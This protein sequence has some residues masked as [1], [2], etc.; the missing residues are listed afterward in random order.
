[1][2]KNIVVACVTGVAR[3]MVACH[4]KDFLPKANKPSQ[5]IYTERVCLYFI[6]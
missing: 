6:V 5:V 3:G 2:F 1:M 4:W